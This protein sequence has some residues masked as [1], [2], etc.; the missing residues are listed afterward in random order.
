M[1][2]YHRI[3]S[4]L[5]LSTEHG[6]RN[7]CCQV[8]GTST[9]GSFSPYQFICFQYQ[10]AQKF[11]ERSTIAV[12]KETLGMMLLAHLLEYALPAQMGSTGSSLRGNF[13]RRTAAYTIKDRG[14]TTRLI[15]SNIILITVLVSFIGDTVMCKSEWCKFGVTTLAPAAYSIPATSA[16]SILQH[17]V[18]SSL[19]KLHSHR[20]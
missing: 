7:G 3:V 10:L 13:A 9:L 4:L 16:G 12:F 1:S 18:D 20:S 11:A 8:T 2:I 6:Q 15:Y 19:N 17:V 14:K 5:G